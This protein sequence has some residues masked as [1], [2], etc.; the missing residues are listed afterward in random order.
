MPPSPHCP[1]VADTAPPEPSILSSI[2]AQNRRLREAL[3]E[4]LAESASN[5]AEI[6]YLNAR[7]AERQA[8]RRSLI[9]ELQAVDGDVR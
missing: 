6:A 2:T 3:R 1:P 5:T 9:Q 8:K 4:A 7:Q